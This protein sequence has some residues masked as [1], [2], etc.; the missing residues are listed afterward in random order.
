MNR[1]TQLQNIAIS[2]A[3]LESNKNKKFKYDVNWN[4]LSFEESIRSSLTLF[5]LAQMQQITVASLNSQR[6]LKNLNIS[7]QM[8]ELLF[9]QIAYTD[10]PFLSVTATKDIINTYDFNYSLQGVS[11]ILTKLNS[12]GLLEKVL[13]KDINEYQQEMTKEYKPPVYVYTVNKKIA[14]FNLDTYNKLELKEF[15][16]STTNIA[17]IANPLGEVLEKLEEILLL[18]P[19]D[20]REQFATKIFPNDK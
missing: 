14:D 5:H 8:V 19:S 13:F 7:D 10:C 9:W 16:N 20:I 1:E 4:S 2:K 17:E 15:I 18:C 12:I 3:R 6:S 11:K